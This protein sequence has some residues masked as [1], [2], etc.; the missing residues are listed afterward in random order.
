MLAL[1]LLTGTHTLHGERLFVILADQSDLSTIAAIADYD[2]RRTRAYDMLVNHAEQSQSDLRAGL[3]RF[4]IEYTPYYL[5][6]AL[7]VRGGPLI[8]LW[9]ASRPEV[10]RVIA[11]PVLRPLPAHAPASSG[12]ATAPQR[13]QWNLTSIGADRVW[14]EFGVTG[15]NIVVG[16]SDSGVQW[17]HPE[18]LSS[19]RGSKEDHNYHWLD[20]W[21]DEQAPIDFGGHGTHTLGSVLGDN[22]GVAP[23]ATWFACA[24]LQRNLGNPALYLDCLQFMLAPYPIDGDPFT[25]GD[26]L[27]SAHVLNNSWGCPP[28]EGC[29]AE[30]L[31]PAVH[32]LRAAGIFVVA[33]AGNEGPNCESIKSPIAIYDDVFSVGAIDEFDELSDFSSIG[34]VTIDG[35]HRTKPDIVA[36]GVDVLSA[37]PQGTFKLASG[38]S[39]AGPHVVGVVALMWSANPNLIGNIET[40]EAILA[41][42]ARPYNGSRPICDG[43]SE[44]PS[45]A[46]GYGL[47]DAY[48]AVERA[49]KE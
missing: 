5:I 47:L 30:A 32:A 10:D 40:T 14:E 22:V 44:N 12:S 3:V 39:M 46:I 33:S 2:E 34:P 13:P 41:E 38:T 16:Q 43:A 21:T 42:T 17:D 49:L 11:S 25:D 6:N 31:Q 48:A 45:T 27:L 20:P 26:A 18:L 4:R 28:I 23:D 36:P 35:S 1:F 29:D 9:L 24:N 15:S 7:E 19:Y 8:R 37:Y